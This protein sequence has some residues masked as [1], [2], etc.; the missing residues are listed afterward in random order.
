MLTIH[1]TGLADYLEGGKGKVKCLLAGASGSGKTR[2]ASFAPKPI[3]AAC[4]DGLMSVADRGVPYAHIH[5][6]EDMAAFLALL[7]QE[8]KK[9]EGQ[10]RWETVV[11]DTI[12][13]YERSVTTHYLK[14][15]KRAEMSGWEDWGYLASR[16]NG[17]IG[18]LS[19]LPMNVIVLVHSKSKT[20]KG[21]TPEEQIVLKLKGELGGAL[22]ED[23]DFVGLIE[24]SFAAVPS[25]KGGVERGITRKITW[26]SLP[27]APWLKCRGGGLTETPVVFAESDFAAIR[28]G[29]RAQ[30]ESLGEGEEVESVET[31]VAATEVLPPEP[32]GPVE[33]PKAKPKSGSA[34]APSPS[35]HVPPAPPVAAPPPAA[36]RPDAGPGVTEE[37]AVQNVQEI[38]GGQIV[39]PATGEVV[40]PT[41]AESTTEA[42]DSSKDDPQTPVSTPDL[43]TEE[44]SSGS[45]VSE[46]PDSGSFTTAC[47]SPRYT[48]GEARAEGC[49][50]PLT[51]TLEG[52]AI[53]S[54]EGD[55]SPQLIEI[56]GIR[57]QAF[58]HN[59]CYAAVRRSRA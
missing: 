18:R 43:A 4:E 8:C 14:K 16:M 11:V 1:T 37:E 49:G 54:A 9:P 15:Q 51:V 59:S 29:I 25:D 42:G 21:Q 46:V 28:D 56:G 2:F 36:P 58:L 27:H 39:D 13:A 57:E 50:K 52:G 30:V 31:P 17:L 6:E 33:K 26:E 7:E 12:D 47:G 44:P 55:E 3:Y 34:P 5:T 23:F 10:R 35:S 40:E 22:P 32:G 19:L 45:G 48:G 41:E 38:L 53:V 20:F 24:A